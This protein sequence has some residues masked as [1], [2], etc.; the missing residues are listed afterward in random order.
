MKDMDILDDMGVSKL[1]ASVF[2]VNYSFKEHFIFYMNAS[3]VTS[4]AFKV[5][6]FHAFPWNQTH[7]LSMIL[8]NSRQYSCC[9]TITRIHF[10]VLWVIDHFF[11]GIKNI[12]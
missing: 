1:S 10:S 2:K 7:D 4:L 3:N 11:F 12:Q 8:S 6:L 5:V 9:C